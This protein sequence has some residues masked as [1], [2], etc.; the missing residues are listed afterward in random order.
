MNQI[1]SLEKMGRKE[2]KMNNSLN[3]YGYPENP[4][5][6]PP[7][8]A[9]TNQKM[10][11][12]NQKY[13]H[14]MSEKSFEHWSREEILLLKHQLDI[15]KEETREANRE[16]REL[17]Q[18]CGFENHD[19]KFCIEL[20]F[21]N[22]KKNTSAPVLDISYIRMIRELT[23]DGNFFRIVWKENPQG[24]IIPESKMNPKQLVKVLESYGIVLKISR[25]KKGEAAEQL[26]QLLSKN[27]SEKQIPSRYGWNR[28]KGGWV[29][30]KE[31]YY[32]E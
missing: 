30:N 9:V 5:T 32:D 6:M 1:N 22:G 4:P 11:L 25:A 3:C 29:F 27:Q 31:E 17:A 15:K 2:L 20:R 28:I 13:L 7:V 12:E 21:P 16:N 10:F 23:Q 19:G 26:F 8:D 24:V 14:R 18:L